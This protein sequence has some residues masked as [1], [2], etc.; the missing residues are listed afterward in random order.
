VIQI[1]AK[2]GG[3]GYQL[4]NGSSRDKSFAV[5][6]GGPAWTSFERLG[7]FDFRETGRPLV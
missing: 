3:I 4:A 1:T 6:L 7:R 2:R 5:Q